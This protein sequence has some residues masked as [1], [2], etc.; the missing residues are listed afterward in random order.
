MAV[1]CATRADTLYKL[2]LQF[3]V[4]KHGGVSSTVF[5]LTKT[6]NPKK[7]SLKLFFPAFPQDQRLRPVTYL[8]HYKG[9]TKEF[10]PGLSDNDPNPLFLSI[11]SPYKPVTSSTLSRW[12]KCILKD[13]GIYFYL[14]RTLH[15]V[16]RYFCGKEQ[17]CFS[18]GHYESCRLVKLK[19]LHQILLQTY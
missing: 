13:S 15:Y 14:Q 10:R 19:Y 11:L 8:K 16:S 2:D 7:S 1:V 9:L 17:K 6:S 3:R 5:Q 12:M 4:F 18:H